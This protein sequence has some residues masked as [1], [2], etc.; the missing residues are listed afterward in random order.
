MKLFTFKDGVLT[1]YKDEIALYPELN[2][3]LVRDKGSV[4]DSDGRKKLQAWKE[5]MYLYMI[6][7]YYSYPNQKGL[8]EREA[9]MY[10]IK[11]AELPKDW[12]PDK[13]ILDA[14]DFYVE[15]NESVAREL[16][17]ELV[18][19]FKNSSRVVKKLRNETEALL[20]KPSLTAV[21]V[22]QLTDMQNTLLDIAV[23]LPKNLKALQE[24]ADL[25][26]K[27]E[28]EG[29]I[30]RGGDMVLDSQDPDKAI[31]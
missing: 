14:M 27:E 21:E 4:G 2:S 31:G 28:Q 22:G 20:A 13:V 23:K 7:D 8:T 10:G 3:I 5:F 26:K 29:E 18:A 30:G 11:E 19:S 1:L 16:N 25:I 17:K 15:A 9:H 12:I 24:S 6:C